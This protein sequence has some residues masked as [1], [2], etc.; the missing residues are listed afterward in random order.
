[1]NRYPPDIHGL[2]VEYWINSASTD[3]TWNPGAIDS[4]EV[5]VDI[6]TLFL[7]ESA[8][9]MQKCLATF[10]NVSNTGM[11]NLAIDRDAI[12]SPSK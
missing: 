10:E 7:D 12:F 5:I 11:H 6:I 2:D 4:S 1:M 9:A 8:V 3:I